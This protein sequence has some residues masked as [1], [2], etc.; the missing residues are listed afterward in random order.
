MTQEE[1]EL[2]Y[3]VLCTIAEEE[4]IEAFFQGVGSS[5]R[6]E[7][8][9]FNGQDISDMTSAEIAAYLA[10]CTSTHGDP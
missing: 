3:D 6:I 7:R 9:T 8:V 1:T 5:P 2:T 10:V 4:A